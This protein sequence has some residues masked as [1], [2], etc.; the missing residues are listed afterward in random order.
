M[1]FKTIAQ[2]L[3]PVIGMKRPAT[4]ASSSDDTALRLGAIINEALENIVERHDWSTMV[5]LAT[6][7]YS[8]NPIP[9]P[10]DYDR[11]AYGETLWR[12]N[13]PDATT[14]PLTPEQWAAERALNYQPLDGN[15]RF[16]GGN[17]ELTD[18]SQEGSYSFEYLSSLPVIGA[19]GDQE[20]FTADD[21]TTYLPERLIR[22]GAK[23]RWKHS[24]GLSYAEDMRDFE[25]AF[26][27][28]AGKDHGGKKLNIGK[29]RVFMPDGVWGGVI[30]GALAEAD[31]LEPE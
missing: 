27:L 1:S 15:W 23:W 28:S 10:D 11:M 9:L 3:S 25:N 20:N 16:I 14:G 7:T 29:R 18:G 22:L 21:D 26:E 17:I 8:G 13:G 6:F 24:N 5:R 30:G 12:A 31:Y 4:V 2:Q 19:E